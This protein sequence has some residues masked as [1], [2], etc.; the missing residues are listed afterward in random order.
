MPGHTG[1]ACSLDVS[2]MDF[3]RGLRPQSSAHIV[4]ADLLAD[5]VAALPG[6]GFHVLSSRPA[7]LRLLPISKDL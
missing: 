7:A 3:A 2:R 1:T 5:P 4:F 6:R